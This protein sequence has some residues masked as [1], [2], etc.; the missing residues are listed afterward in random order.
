MCLEQLLITFLTFCKVCFS[1]QEDCTFHV[2]LVA[3]WVRLV[4]P[5][6]VRLTY[7]SD[8]CPEQ[9][10]EVSGWGLLCWRG[11]SIP[12]SLVQNYFWCVFYSS[13]VVEILFVIASSFDSLAY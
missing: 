10:A 2:N 1:F 8:L 5:G 12:Q 4:Q 7:E 3:I 13:A 6:R 11:F 9:E